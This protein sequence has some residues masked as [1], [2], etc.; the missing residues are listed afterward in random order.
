MHHPP[1]N[2]REKEYHSRIRKVLA[3]IQ[4][5][6][7]GELSLEKLAEIA[8]FSPFHFQKLFS[9]YI[10]ETPKH[11]IMR[12][13][14]ERIAHHLKLYPALSITD[15][16]FQCGF[17]SPSTFIRAF[18]KYYGTTPEVFRTLSFDDISKIGTLKPDNCKSFHIHPAEFWS[19]DLTNEKVEGSPAAMDIKVNTVRSLNVA[20][21]ESHL[22][23]DDAIPNTFKALARWAEPRD[24]ITKKT[25]F[26]GILLDMPFFTEYDKCRFRACITVPEGISQ[27]R[28]IGFAKISGGKYATYFYK[29]T[30]ESVFQSLAVFKHEW[31]DQSGYQIAEITGFELYSENP[32]EKPYESIPRQIFIPVR[33]E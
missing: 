15:A 25:Q 27:S 22:G 13:R 18:K 11:Y 20:F 32:A 26:I 29:G 28:E 31:L 2:Q 12:L 21:L 14:M 1:G 30:I 7:S 19:L 33:P 16:S 24:L 4:E 9:L 8:F 10:G 23:D 17:S 3:Y 6:L 5:N